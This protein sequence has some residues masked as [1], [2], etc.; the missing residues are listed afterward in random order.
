[1]AIP[2]PGGELDLG[3]QDRLDPTGVARLGARHVGERRVRP[4]V[5]LKLIRVT[6]SRPSFWLKPVPTLP[7]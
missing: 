2:R 1:M 7:A 5:F 4:A 3:D 6:R